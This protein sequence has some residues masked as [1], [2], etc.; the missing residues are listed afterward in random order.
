MWVA[1]CENLP[2]CERVDLTGKLYTVLEDRLWK[3]F[4]NW[5]VKMVTLLTNTNLE[6]KFCLLHFFFNLC[7]LH[8]FYNL[9]LFIFKMLCF[10]KCTEENLCLC[11][12]HIIKLISPMSGT[13]RCQDKLN[14]RRQVIVLSWTTLNKL[15]LFHQQL[16]W[17]CYTS[18]YKK[19]RL[20][21]HIAGFYLSE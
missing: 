12:I 9:F 14:R 3:M 8:Y 13:L 7:L 20:G 4:W 2:E 5:Q 1:H 11:D 10:I 21:S 6:K 18:S 16:W 17:E 15:A 19:L